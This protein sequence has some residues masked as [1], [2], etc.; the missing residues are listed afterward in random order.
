MA[1]TSV[2]CKACHD[3][4][5]PDWPCHYCGNRAHRARKDAADTAEL[6]RRATIER[7][8]AAAHVRIHGAER[9]RQLA[10][11]IAA[12]RA[13]RTADHY[14]RS[15]RAEQASDRAHRALADL[16]YWESVL[17]QA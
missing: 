1:T 3:R 10:H 8:R 6:R 9:D 5:T 13:G 2:L 4:G 14:E 15:A 11:A 16:R 12:E 7:D 17:E